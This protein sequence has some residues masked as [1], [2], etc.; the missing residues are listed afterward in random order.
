MKKL[1]LI[2][3]KALLV[4]FCAALL[5]IVGRMYQKIDALTNQLTYMQDSTS[6]ILSDMGNL[7]SNIE[8]TLQEEASM[9]EDYSI[10]VASLNFANKTYRVDISVV[11]KEYTDKTQVSIFFGTLECPL[12]A[13]KYA[14]TG[15]VDLPLDKSFD[16]NVTFLLSNGRKKTT[17][18]LNDY[19]LDLGLDY[20]LSA[21]L[22]KAP[23]YRNGEIRLNSV[24]DVQLQGNGLF[25]F[26][27]LDLVTM[28]DDKQ[29]N[30]TDLLA[31]MNGSDVQE[32]ANTSDGES[33][34]STEE[35]DVDATESDTVDSIYGSANAEF[36]YELPEV[37]TEETDTDIPETQHVRI[38]VCAKTKEGYRFE[39][40]VFEGDYLALEEKMDQDS[41]QWNT[42]NE[43]YDRNGNQLELDVHEI[44]NDV[45]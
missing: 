33:V 45:N 32:E 23:V 3:K 30:V 2:W 15:S 11:P 17:E 1:K 21:K 22:E 31:Q 43:A 24:C 40:T 27:N 38:S 42:S 39:Y 18:V 34:D 19:R 44:N 8:K 13:G 28:L 36:T 7:Q 41:F 16:D 4:A 5:I 25:E 35:K 9:V 37:D 20:V 10:T 14:Y 26:E 12:V 6:V 29:I